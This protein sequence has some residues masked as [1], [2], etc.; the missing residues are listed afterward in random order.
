[1]LKIVNEVNRSYLFNFCPVFVIGII[2][3]RWKPR[4]EDAV[5]WR[6]CIAGLNEIFM[7]HK[8]RRRGPL[9]CEGSFY[10]FR[11]V[12]FTSY[13]MS[14][15]R[16]LFGAHRAYRKR[17]YYFW[18]LNAAYRNSLYFDIFILSWTVVDFPYAHICFARIYLWSDISERTTSYM[19]REN[20]VENEV[21]TGGQL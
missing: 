17:V 11:R 8:E 5:L 20:N 15:P 3:C 19:P 13:Q 6:C 10:L 7:Q 1:M 12:F 18:I 4:K 21:E 16:V 14:I 9:L 2:E